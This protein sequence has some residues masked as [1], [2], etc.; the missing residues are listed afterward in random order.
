M[1][2]RG[3]TVTSAAMLA[4]LASCASPMQRSAPL[5]Q[6]YLAANPLTKESKAGIP[7]FLP[8][9]VVPVTVSGDFVLLPGRKA[10][11][12]TPA[13]YEYVI[14]VS[15]GAAKQVPD[16]NAAL[17]LEYVPEMAS[18]DVFKLNVGANG[19]LSNVK[20]TSSDQSAAIIL[21]LV[22]LAKE[23]IT[24]P[25]KFGKTMRTAPAGP[26]DADRRIAC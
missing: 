19:L 26:S 25:S 20:S 17:M 4:V 22:E 15:I 16:S 12:A 2:F 1:N 18:D 11:D 21:K 5:S 8:D 9:T 10:D 13:D 6:Q 7:Y 3:L 23:A 14:S 24:L